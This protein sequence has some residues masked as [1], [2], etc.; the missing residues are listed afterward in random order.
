MRAYGEKE[1]IYAAT[2][3]IS[4]RQ[5]EI[6]DVLGNVRGYMEIYTLETMTRLAKQ[7]YETD[8]EIAYWAYTEQERPEEDDLKVKNKEYLYTLIQYEGKDVL[9]HIGTWEFTQEVFTRRDITKLMGLSHSPLPL[10]VVPAREKKEYPW[11]E[12]EAIYK[13][14]VVR[15]FLDDCAILYSPKWWQAEIRTPK[16]W[17]H[18][19]QHGQS[20]GILHHKDAMLALQ[21]ALINKVCK[22]KG[23]KEKILKEIASLQKL[24]KKEFLE[25]V[26]G[27][28]KYYT[29]QQ[30]VLIDMFEK[31]VDDAVDQ[32]DESWA[33]AP[34]KRITNIYAMIKTFDVSKL[35]AK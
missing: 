22:E 23:E 26:N 29:D 1:H 18:D 27:K 7:Y 2:T 17:W 9:L 20:N 21:E 33:D 34:N 4:D 5:D 19:I 13:H 35:A 6:A 15:R 11:A 31:M 12:K 8:E 32:W 3:N 16:H 14:A 30:R 28:E 25:W 24:S 10:F